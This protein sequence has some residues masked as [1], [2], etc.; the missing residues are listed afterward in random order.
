MRYKKLLVL[1]LIAFGLY[2]ITQLCLKKTD[3]FMMGEILSSRSF[4]NRFVTRPLSAKEEEEVQSALKQ[5]YTYYGCGGQA[6]IFFSEDGKHA[7]K[8]FKQRHFREPT[9]LNYI[10]FVDTYRTRKYNKRRKRLYLDYGSYKMAFEELARE[11]EVIYVHLNKTD[12]LRQK[13]RLV[14]NLHIEHEVDLDSTDFILQRKG[15]LVHSQINDRMGKQDIAGAQKAIDM[16]IDLIKT[17]C[18]KEIRDRDPNIATN[19]GIYGDHA[20]KVDVG[21]FTHEK[22]YADPV[23][24]RAEIFALTRPFRLWLS[25]KHPELVSYLDERVTKVIAYE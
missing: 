7:L 12:H 19:C 14:D 25:Q 16:V 24:Y 11:T 23:V 15:V 9:Y 3:K 21:R 5:K 17:R 22:F 20:F 10:P 1:S 13:I 18:K 6:Y 4:E 2:G 8:F